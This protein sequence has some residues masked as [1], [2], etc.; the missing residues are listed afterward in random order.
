MQ[1]SYAKV[2][3]AHIYPLAGDIAAKVQ[4]REFDYFRRDRVPVISSILMEG[5]PSL[6]A[7]FGIEVIAVP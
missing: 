6:D 1:T 5:L 7:S 2:V 4:A 3:V